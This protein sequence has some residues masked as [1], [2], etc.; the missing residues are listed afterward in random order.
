MKRF[1]RYFLQ[2]QLSTPVLVLLI[3]FTPGPLIPKVILA[4]M[5]ASLVYFKARSGRRKRAVSS[6][7]RLRRGDEFIPYR[8]HITLM[9]KLKVF[10]FPRKFPKER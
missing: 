1:V 6:Y 5:V 3:V 10:K 2:W 9:N 7:M 8:T 4:N